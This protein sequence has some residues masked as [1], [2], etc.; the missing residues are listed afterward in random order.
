MMDDMAEAKRIAARLPKDVKRAL[1]EDG[2]AIPDSLWFGKWSH[3]RATVNAYTWTWS[4]FGLAVRAAIAAMAP[5]QI[6]E[7]D[8]AEEW[9][10]IVEKFRK[11]GRLREHPHD[12][13]LDLS[14]G[15]LHIS[16]RDSKQTT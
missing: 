13:P 7:D 12:G 11:A 16:R 1:T 3:L 10:D 6:A 4:G 15:T 5:E 9:A 2:A 8:A 14:P